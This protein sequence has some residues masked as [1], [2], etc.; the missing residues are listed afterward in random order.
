MAETVLVVEDDS[1][2]A[3]VVTQNLGLLGLQFEHVTDGEEGLSRAL[4]NNY[5]LLI[6][7]VNIP[8]VSGLDVCKRVRSEKQ[9]LPIL[10]LTAR[11]EE[12]DRVLGLELGADDYV[13]KPFSIRELTAR[14]RALL[15]RAS[16]QG[17][18]PDSPD[19]VEQIVARDL[20]VDL[21]RRKVSRGDLFIELTNIE[22]ELLAF[23]AANPGR[24]FTREALVKKV[25]G[26]SA[27]NY[28]STVNA[29]LCRLRRKIEPNPDQ[30]MYIKTVWGF[31][32]E[33]TDFAK[34]DEKAEPK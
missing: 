4:N 11:A 16:F 27:S 15:R 10:M 2:I 22:F 12:I 7:D 20:I 33:F 28:E 19:E 23:L 32:Y 13:T 3:K 21:K 1:E 6:L 24:P 26:Y 14:V 5:S 25:W 18:S 8:K 17:P 30:P 9:S 34:L 31:G 29:Q